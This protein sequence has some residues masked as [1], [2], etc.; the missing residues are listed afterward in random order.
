MHCV[1]EDAPGEVQGCPRSFRRKPTSIQVTNL[2]MDAEDADEKSER[3]PCTLTTTMLRAANTVIPTPT[4]ISMSIPTT[5]NI[6]MTMTTST[7]TTPILL[8]RSC[9]CHGH[10]TY[11]QWSQSGDPS[12]TLT[13]KDYGH[14]NA[15]GL[16][17]ECTHGS[18]CIVS[19]SDTTTN[20]CSRWQ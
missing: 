10:G 12:G 4:S 5:T 11:W 8:W 3:L 9:Y 20:N 1:A 16:V 2:F 15:G 6:C 7:T 17:Y 19:G 14:Y 13:R 18:K